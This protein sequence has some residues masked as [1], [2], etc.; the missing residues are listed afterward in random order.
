LHVGAIGAINRHDAMSRV[1]KGTIQMKVFCVTE[2]NQIRVLAS[3]REAPGG[4]EAFQSQKE[5]GALAV[6]WPSSRLVQIWNQL[7]GVRKITKFTNRNTGVQ[8]LWQALEGELK[9]TRHTPRV[10]AKQRGQKKPVRRNTK[11]DRMLALL[12]RPEG[13]SL[14]MLMKTT[15]WQAHSVRGFLSAQV[16]K[17]MGLKVNSFRREGQRVYAIKR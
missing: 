2:D 4:A 10:T 14:Q 5:L 1:R 3:R 7:T 13:V 8:R 9:V 15:E 6:Q 16:T 12:D 11:T 17:R